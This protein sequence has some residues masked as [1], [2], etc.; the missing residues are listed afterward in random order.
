MELHTNEKSLDGHRHIEADA[1]DRP[2]RSRDVRVTVAGRLVGVYSATDLCTCDAEV[3]R[4]L[5]I[6][7]CPKN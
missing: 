3:A 2:P 6:R 1:A 5:R 7:R 4:A